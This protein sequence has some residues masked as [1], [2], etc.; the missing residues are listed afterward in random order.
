[1][2][3]PNYVNQCLE[4]LEAAG[5]AAYAVGGCVRDACL[6]LTPHDYD[7]CTSAL[8]EQTEAV[9]SGF[10]LVLAGK[11]HGTVGVITEGGVVEITTFRTEGEY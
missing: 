1:M 11:K 8:P 2:Y 6:G 10:S 7:L 3:I 5:F 4:A 9:F